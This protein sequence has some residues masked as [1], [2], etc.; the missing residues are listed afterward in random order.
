MSLAKLQG[1]A[2]HPLRVQDR[3]DGHQ[4]ILFRPAHKIRGAA[5]H[6]SLINIAPL[7]DP[8]PHCA[9]AQCLGGQIKNTLRVFL[10][11]PPTRDRTWDLLL[12]R[13]LLYRLSYRR[14]CPSACVPLLNKGRQCGAVSTPTVAEAW[15]ICP[16]ACVPLLKCS[17]YLG[18]SQPK[19]SRETLL[20]GRTIPQY[21]CKSKAHYCGGKALS[22]LRATSLVVYQL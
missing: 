4:R 10:I 17:T 13:E 11:C 5:G 15:R 6:S 14:I 9:Q 3:P 7:F 22:S 1:F 16:S 21:I 20:S 12:K 2:S 8:W 19:W 18:L